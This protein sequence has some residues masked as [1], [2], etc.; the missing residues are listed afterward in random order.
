[1]RDA[2]EMDVLA[3]CVPTYLRPEMLAQC[4]AKLRRI[5]RPDDLHCLVIVVDNDSEGSA[6]ATFDASGIA[7]SFDAIYAIE[8]ERGLGQVRNRCLDEAIARDASLMAFIDDDEFP[9]P[10]WL[11]GLLAAMRKFNAP[12]VR[13]PVVQLPWESRPDFDFAA[14]KPK[15]R[16][17]TGDTIPHVNTNNAIFDL[18]LAIEHELRFDPF[19]RFVAGEDHDFFEQMVAHSGREAIWCAEAII[20]EV[21]VEERRRLRNRLSRAYKGGAANVAKYRRRNSMLKT[22]LYFAGKSVG[23]MA[24]GL[25]KVISGAVT[26]KRRV[27]TGLRDWASAAGYLAG[28]T[29][30]YTESYRVTDGE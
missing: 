22:E 14:A 8:N 18:R 12:I 16:R 3:I 19:F 11:I 30:W 29:G 23:K 9:E 20:Y 7:D 13:G 1:M 6:R 25:L 5:E 15:W 4:L 27:I 28:M 17:K 21:V 2:D 10:N 24:A 26:S